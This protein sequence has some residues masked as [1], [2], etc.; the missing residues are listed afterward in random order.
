MTL[1]EECKEALLVDFNIVTGD[2]EKKALDVLYSYPVAA[3]GV[4]WKEI[5]Y[6]DYDNLNDVLSANLLKKLMC[7]S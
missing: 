3:G 5:K 6:S 2:A 1:F 4:L 7:L